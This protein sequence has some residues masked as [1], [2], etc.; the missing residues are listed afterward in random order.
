MNSAAIHSAKLIAEFEKE[1]QAS[2]PPTPR[3]PS[4]FPFGAP[5]AGPF[6]GASAATSGR[7]TMNN[8]ADAHDG[9]AADVKPAS[10][11]VDDGASTYQPRRLTDFDYPGGWGAQT[12]SGVGGLTQDSASRIA[13]LQAKLNQRLGPEYLSQRPGPGG[14]K[15]LTYIEGWKVIDLANEVFGFNGW[16]TTIRKLE[17]DFLDSPDGTRWSAGVTCIL[18]VTLRDGAFHEDVGYGSADNAR[19]KHVA[20]EKCKKEAV[21]DATKRALK[22][23]GKLLGNCLYDHQYS[24]H[25]LKVTNPPPKFDP[26][27][28]HR[29]PELRPPPPP[30][31]QPQPPQTHVQAAQP[32]RKLAPAPAPAPAPSTSTERAASAT[33][34]AAETCPAAAAPAPVRPVVAVAAVPQEAMEE[35]SKD[36]VSERQQRSM[37]ARQAYLERQQAEARKQAT[38]SPPRAEVAPSS[39]SFDDG[40]LD[41]LAYDESALADA[42]AASHALEMQIDQPRRVDDSTYGADDSGVAFAPE[43]GQA[44]KAEK[45]REVEMRRS[46]SPVKQVKTEALLPRRA[47]SVGRFVSP[48][49]APAPAVGMMRNG[50]TSLSAASSAGRVAAAGGPRR[51]ASALGAGVGV[52]G[53]VSR[54][55]GRAIGEPVNHAYVPPEARGVKRPGEASVERS[56]PP[57]PPSLNLARPT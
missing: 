13:T 32:P 6:G 53:T 51:F 31:P 5:A 33:N 41:E 1:Q 56:A 12:F 25:A 19:Q 27:E 37:L 52:E 47:G 44:I 14:V 9:D 39:D 16:S 38:R 24:T 43:H 35:A 3:Y 57:A 11:P 29:R 10:A 49:P 17:I 15:R 22:N 4:E 18:R 30:Q 42:E 8:F 46:T 55:A 23:F 48:P 21:T 20:I 50:A 40:L 36:A 28:L 45:T 7:S 2:L 54:E 26:A 34:G